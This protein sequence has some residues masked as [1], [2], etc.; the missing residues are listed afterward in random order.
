MENFLGGHYAGNVRFKSV[1]GSNRYP[2]TCCV[3]TRLKGIVIKTII[4]RDEQTGERLTKSWEVKGS[5]NSSGIHVTPTQEQV[6]EFK[7]LCLEHTFLGSYY[8][9]DNKGKKK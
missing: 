9:S 6:V 2:A 3:L 7:Q 8:H 1:G 4:Y 5:R